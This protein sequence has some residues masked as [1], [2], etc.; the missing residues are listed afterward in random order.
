MAEETKVDQWLEF[1]KAGMA[2]SF[3]TTQN[4]HTAAMARQRDTSMHGLKVI[5]GVVAKE[6]LVSDDPTDYARMNTAIRTP[7]TLDHPNAVVAK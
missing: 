5:E 4:D 2:E 7:T 1:M 3:R 6:L